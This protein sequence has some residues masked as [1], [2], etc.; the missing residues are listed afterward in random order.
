MSKKNTSLRLTERDT[1]YITWIA[2]QQALI[3]K[4]LPFGEICF[5]FLG[6]NEDFLESSH[7]SNSVTSHLKIRELMAMGAGKEGSCIRA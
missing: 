1:E 4:T 2:E 7:C 6:F 3:T 5:C